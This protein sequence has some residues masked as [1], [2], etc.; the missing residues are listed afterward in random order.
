M[1]GS[2]VGNVCILAC[3]LSVQCLLVERSTRTNSQQ[4]LKS[5]RFATGHV[6]A[7]AREGYGGADRQKRQVSKCGLTDADVLDMEPVSHSL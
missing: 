3:I 4:F 2:V 6:S 5:P 7:T 1:A